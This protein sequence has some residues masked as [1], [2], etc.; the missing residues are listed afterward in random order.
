MAGVAEA[1]LDAPTLLRRAAAELRRLADATAGAEPVGADARARQAAQEL[2]RVTQHLC[3]LGEVLEALAEGAPAEAA[4][5]SVGNVRLATM[6]R[7][8]QDPELGG[9]I[10]LF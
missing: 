4:L 7:D 5:A 8:G 2:D 3:G 1:R 9:E 6:L 10:E